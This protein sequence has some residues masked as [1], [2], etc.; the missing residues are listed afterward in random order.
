M[1]LITEIN[2]EIEQIVNANAG[3][4]KGGEALSDIGWDSMATVMFIAM[5]DEKFSK[6]I[7]PDSLAEAKTVSDLHVLLGVA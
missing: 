2:R 5:A 6:A 1:N 7:P 3:S 4:I